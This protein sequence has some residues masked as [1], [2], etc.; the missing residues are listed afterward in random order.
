[1]FVSMATT[2]CP[3]AARAHDRLETSVVLPIPPFPPM[4]PITRVIIINV[5]S[6]LLN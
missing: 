3:S 4:T 6:V 1:M 5:N 2:F